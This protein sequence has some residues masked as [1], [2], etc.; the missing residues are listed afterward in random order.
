MSGHLFCP[1]S[2]VNDTGLILIKR[3]SLI[4]TENVAFYSITWDGNRGVT[5]CHFFLSTNLVE[6]KVYPL[7]L[8]LVHHVHILCRVRCSDWRECSGCAGVIFSIFP[9]SYAHYHLVS[10]Q[11]TNTYDLIQTVATH[12]HLHT[13]FFSLICQSFCINLF[14]MRV[15]YVRKRIIPYAT[16]GA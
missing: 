6:A 11:H 10:W 16:T 4:L 2:S 15:I 12:R 8:P 1:I 5:G 13:L 14:R 9:A 3:F 7:L